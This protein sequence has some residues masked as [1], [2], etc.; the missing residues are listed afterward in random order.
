MKILTYQTKFKTEKIKLTD[1]IDSL[2]EV[3][4]NRIADRINIVMDFDESQEV[5]AD[6]EVLVHILLSLFSNAVDAIS[7]TGEIRFSITKQDQTQV[8]EIS[9]TGQGINKEELP[10]I[11][12][13]FY[14]GKRVGKGT[15]IGLYVVKNLID[16][17][18]WD[19]E[20][21]SVPGKGTTI[22]LISSIIAG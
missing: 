16:K 9:D 1:I 17:M 5:L 10:M 18:G 20:V 12:N 22:S 21:Q 8:I 15:G 11:F 6:R 14:T 2:Q 19:I 4:S 7:D 13:A 3:F